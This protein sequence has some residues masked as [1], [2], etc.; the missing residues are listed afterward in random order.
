[1]ECGAN[2]AVVATDS[3]RIVRGG[4]N[5]R[6]FH[7]IFPAIQELHQRHPGDR[8]VFITLTAQSSD[9][10]LPVV[11]KRFKKWLAKLQRTQEWQRCIRGA[12]VGFECVYHPGQGWHFHAHILAS[13]MAW[14]AQEDLA[15][16]WQRVSGEMGR[17]VDIRAVKDLESGVAETL[18]YAFKPTNLLTWGASQVGQLNGLGRTKVREC[19]GE[20]RGLVGE[21]ERDDEEKIGIEPEERPVAE[22]ESCPTCAL[23]L[24]ARW[25]SREALQAATRG[26][27][28]NASSG[29]QYRSG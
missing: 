16:S 14:W 10:P 11:V 28:L 22:G 29:V 23:P 25:L 12:V 3:A 24:T 19:Y 4:G 20:M 27:N 15:A 1:V 13:R 8:W 21:L 18:K 7:R 9:E 2:G 26:A 5:A 6:A 17:I